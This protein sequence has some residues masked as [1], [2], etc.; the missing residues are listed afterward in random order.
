M[1]SGVENRINDDSRKGAKGAKFGEM[2]KGIGPR[3]TRAK[4]VLPSTRA[5]AEG[6][7]AE[8]TQR[9]PRSEKWEE[10]LRGKV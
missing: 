6:S 4:P 1:N 3:M 10:H 2:G 5:Q 9:A 8:G 7:D